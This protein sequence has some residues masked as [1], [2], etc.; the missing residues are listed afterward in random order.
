[1]NI[2]Y[3]I[4]QNAIDFYR[5]KG[6]KYIEVPWMV[7]GR[8][9]NITLPTEME[10]FPALSKSLVGSGE[11]SFL[12][13]IMQQNLSMGNYVCATPCYRPYDE[14]NDGLHF[15]Q[16]YKVEL[17]SYFKI[18]A[19]YDF[20]SISLRNMLDCAK[21]FMEITRNES[22][23]IIKTEDEKRKGCITIESYDIVTKDN[24]ELGSYGIRIGTDKK[25]DIGYWIYGTGCALPRLMYGLQ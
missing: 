18:I 21:S 9:I 16:F 17:I 23:E 11:Q 12:S 24:I 1:M 10:S 15:P 5:S 13:L 19:N 7:L 25:D 20:I 8:D 3:N 2:K 14:K 4:I 22:L 6:Y